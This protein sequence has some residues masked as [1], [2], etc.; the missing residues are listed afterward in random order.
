MEIKLYK[1]PWRAVKLINLCSILVFGGIFIL[2][3][4]DAPKW[5]GWMSIRFFGL[6]YPVGLFHLLDRRPQIIIN[7]AGIFDRTTYKYFINWEVIQDA[8]PINISAQKFVW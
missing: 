2:S 3:Q 4:P 8:Y 5:V 7:E 1:S 6:G